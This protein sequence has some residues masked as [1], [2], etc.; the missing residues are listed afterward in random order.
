MVD[1]LADDHSNAKLLEEGLRKINGIEIKNPVMTNMVY[2][3][4]GGLG[5]NGDDF[6]EASKKLGWKTRGSGTTLRLCTHY[7]IEREDIEAFIT[8]ITA[9][10]PEV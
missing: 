10:V 7:G 2:I 1:R 4:I 9:A 8:G 6:K 3:D 5:W